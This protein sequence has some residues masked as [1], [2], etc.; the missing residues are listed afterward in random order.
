MISVALIAAIVAADHIDKDAQITS[1]TNEVNYDGTYQ[2]SFSSSNGISVQ[3]SGTGGHYASGSAQYYSPEGVPI[4]LT[5]TADEN[6][7]QPKGD[8]LP[9]PPPI[10]DHVLKTL[11]Y[12]RTHPQPQ[13]HY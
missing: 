7:Y 12:I 11:E 5:Y 2:H 1:Q 9:T 10:P 13:E 6:G 8:H 3:E 4:A